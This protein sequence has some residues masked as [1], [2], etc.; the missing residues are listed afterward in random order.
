MTNNGSKKTDMLV[1][2]QPASM[3][4][5]AN[6]RGYSPADMI[7]AIAFI[8]M[9]APAMYK[10]GYFG[11]ASPEQAVVV[12]L[13]AYELGFPV[14]SAFNLVHVINTGKGAQVTVSPRGA[15]ALVHASGQL[16]DMKV[17][18]TQDACEVYM[19][20]VNGI[21]YTIKFTIEQARAAKLIKTGGAWEM[22]QANMLKWRAIGFA[23]D[24]LFP[25]VAGGIARADTFGAIVNAQG[26]VIDVAGECG[27]IG[28]LETDKACPSCGMLA[29]EIA[30]EVK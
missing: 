10:A 15:L 17:I 5:L 4:T 13:T 12:M 8:Q 11:I 23:I 24:V 28:M 18:E 9:A 3:A 22:W 6:E 14:T 27:H 16:A 26:D 1:Y 30:K 29:E 21:E 20:R 25:D 7:Q 19:R 2:Q